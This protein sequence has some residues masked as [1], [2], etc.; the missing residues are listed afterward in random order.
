LIQATRKAGQQQK[1]LLPCLFI[2][3]GQPA[4]IPQASTLPPLQAT[5][6]PIPA[7]DIMP[8]SLPPISMSVEAGTPKSQRNA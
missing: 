5:P 2:Y 1:T 3:P 8:D 6:P 7:A 4:T